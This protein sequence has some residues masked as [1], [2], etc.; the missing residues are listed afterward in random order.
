MMFVDVYSHQ[1]LPGSIKV[2]ML[3]GYHPEKTLAV[4]QEQWVCFGG[5]FENICM[6]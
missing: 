1:V 2:V 5:V 6:A 3:V 4:C